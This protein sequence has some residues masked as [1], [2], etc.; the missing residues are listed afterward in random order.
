MYYPP[1]ID[2]EISVVVAGTGGIGS[3]LV[4]PLARLLDTISQRMSIRIS[5]HLVDPDK[6]SWKNVNRQNFFPYEIN[7]NKA[8]VLAK[9]V[10]SGTVEVYHHTQLEKVIPTI[11]IACVDSPEARKQI[12]EYTKNLVK[13]VTIIDAGNDDEFGQVLVGNN[14]FKGNE[15]KTP[16]DLLPSPYEVFPELVSMKV[17]KEK[18]LSCAERVDLGEQKLST[19]FFCASLILRTMEYL[20]AGEM[21]FAGF[22]FYGTSVSPVTFEEVNERW[23]HALRSFKKKNKSKASLKP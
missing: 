5:L 1:I 11:L 19:N 17:K 9:R 13:V 21:A 7:Q 23:K 15:I 12:H 16:T 10:Y 2:R 14:H 18:R 6:V 3:W 8:K 4:E 20:F 22:R